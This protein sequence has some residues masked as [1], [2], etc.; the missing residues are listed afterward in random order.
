MQLLGQN[1]YLTSFAY[2]LLKILIKGPLGRQP[3]A[4][5]PPG[6]QLG[7]SRPFGCWLR[8]RGPPGR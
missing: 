8:A 4:P 3:G 2:K 5:G 1:S 6:S 7:V